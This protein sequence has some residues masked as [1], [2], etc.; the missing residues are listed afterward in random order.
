MRRITH[1]RDT[2]RC[3]T[4]DRIAIEKRPFPLIGSS[5]QQFPRGFG[6]SRKT[7]FEKPRLT[8]ARPE[9]RSIRAK[10]LVH[11]RDDIDDGAAAQGIMDEMRLGPEPKG[12]LCPAHV[13]VDA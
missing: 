3:P 9:F 7:C 6:P 8:R 1:E 13:R 10:I 12:C 4:C 5:A 2:P 11:D